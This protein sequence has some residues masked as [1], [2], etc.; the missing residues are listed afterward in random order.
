MGFSYKDRKHALNRRTFLLGAGAA[1]AT[2]LLAGKASAGD[3]VFLADDVTYGKGFEGVQPTY[4]TITQP[5]APGL[6]QLVSGYPGKRPMIRLTTRPPQLETPFSVFNEGILTPNDAFFV[7]YHGAPLPAW[8]DGAAFRLR[9]RGSV[10][11]GLRFSVADL[12]TNFPEREVVAVNQCSGNSRGFFQPRI[13]GGQYGNGA[14]GNARWTGVSL[15]DVLLA[16]GVKPSAKQVVF[17]GL[18][19]PS[20]DGPDFIK[21][22]D[23]DH[24]MSGE[25]MLAY[26]M[27][28]EDIPL[29]NGYPLRVVAPGYYGTYWVKHVHDIQVIDNTLDQF[30]MNPAYRIPNN[31][32][33]CVPPGTAPTST[34]PINR[35]NVRSFITSVQD[36]GEMLAG[37]IITVRGIAFDG[38][39]GISKVLFSSDGGTNWREANLGDDLG[40]HSFREWKIDL[41]VGGPGI[42]ELKSKAFNWYGETQPDT[43]LWNPSGYMR[44]VI[45]TVRVLAV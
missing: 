24:V 15:R 3:G 5:F 11:K 31:A 10:N 9:V 19:A 16:A 18:D 4:P 12:M 28:G 32:C 30:Y 26:K 38:G 35:M 25:V 34:V 29:L 22:L 45:E 41:A 44:N 17:S 6:R 42:Y 43:P 37:Q 13:K 2:A 36:G 39:R 21:A 23:I 40:N 27:N 20:E 33:A 7:R 1:G 8:I 14:M